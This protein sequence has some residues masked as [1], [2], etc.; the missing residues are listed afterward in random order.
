MPPS[1]D[2]GQCRAVTDRPTDR[3]YGGFVIHSLSIVS[4]QADLGEDV[5]VGPFT[6]VHGNVRIGAGSVIGSH[7][8]IGHPTPLAEH[9]PLVIGPSALVRSH[10]VL[11]E[12]SEFGD[13]LVTGHRV[14]LREKTVAGRDFHVGTLGDVQGHCNIGD[15]VRLHSNVHVGQRSRIG[16]FVWVFPYVVLTNDPHP[17]SEV[18]RGV[19]LEDYS[20]VAT[21]SVILP[22]VTVGAGAVVG[23]HS[24]VTRDVAPDT[25][26]VGVPARRVG[27]TDSIQ[28]RDGTG[29]PA[30]PWRRH[31]HRGYPPEVVERWILEFTEERA[32]A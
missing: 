20:V 16:N 4:P 29:G 15:Y 27:R 21:M 31:F 30:Y 25:V 22:G 5:H 14:T 2:I 32:G 6:V 18:L 13:R 26:V 28:L 24:S 3:H 1:V 12:G 8:E 10:S 7:C 19:T 11:Y 23:A 9:R 17:P